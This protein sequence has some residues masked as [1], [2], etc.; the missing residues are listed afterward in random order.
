MFH[1]WNIQILVLDR[2][3]ELNEFSKHFCN[4]ISLDRIDIW[5]FPLSNSAGDEFLNFLLSWKF[6]R[7]RNT[8]RDSVRHEFSNG[9]WAGVWWKTICH[10]IHKFAF[11][12]FLL[13]SNARRHN[14]GTPLGDLF[15][16]AKNLIG[17]SSESFKIV[18]LFGNLKSFLI[19]FDFVN[20]IPIRVVHH[21][22]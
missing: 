3:L 5:I 1:I 6:F 19:C 17:Q 15:Y 16:R 12:D 22:Y 18:P 11:N 2:A 14:S 9:D 7:T 4:G 13:E 10:K 21:R 20:A 8:S